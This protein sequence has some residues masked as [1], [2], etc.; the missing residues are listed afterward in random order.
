MISLKKFPVT[1]KLQFGIVSIILIAL[2]SSSI[3]YIAQNRIS[4]SYQIFKTTNSSDVLLNKFLGTLTGNTLGYMDAIVDKDA[5]KVD[6]DIVQGHLDFKKWLVG[7]KENIRQ[8]FL[9][10]DPNSNSRFEEIIKNSEIYWNAGDAMIKDINNKKIDELDKYDDHIDGKNDEMKNSVIEM[11]TISGNK[12]SAA[13][14]ELEGAQ[15][16]LKISGIVSS[17][18]I[19]IFSFTI[20]YFLIRD[21]KL[22]LNT[23]G[24]ELSL[25]S[26]TVL[27]AA[28]EFNTL[29]S[30][31]KDSTNKQAS[32]LHQTSSA[33]VE[34]KNTVE[35]NS[36]LTTVSVDMV[37]NCKQSAQKGKNASQDM[38]K[39]IEEINVA[40][41]ET[42][43][44]LE[45]TSNDVKDMVKLIETINQKTSVINDIVFQT[46]LLS[47]NASVEAARAGEHG[48]GFAVVAEEVGNLAQMSGNAAQEINQLLSSSVVKVEGIV[49]NT[50]SRKGELQRKTTEMVQRGKSTS[51][52]SDQYLSDI[53]EKLE[54]LHQMIEEI[55]QASKEQTEGITSIS[56][57]INN[58]DAITS[59]NVQAANTCAHS[60][61]TLSDQSTKLTHSVDVLFH[62]VI[63]Q[64]LKNT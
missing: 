34:I 30:Q 55:N 33:I 4:K 23:V 51:L 53:A 54:S 19:F 57:A 13:S 1:K 36:E 28:N 9:H 47:F 50:D 25:G 56:D 39:A 64:N 5:F 49:K 63:G 38:L 8:S 42:I 59:E 7:E 22:T 18:A 37:K 32:A 16:V 41:Q 27:K 45:T 11:L 29:S 6:D 15:F 20:L 48:K 35:R 21:I 31:I 14:K 40:Q 61:E 17:L 3:N 24:G 52:E 46:K 10:L 62:T 43:D 12:F 58:L 44:T 60:A 2:V 26:T